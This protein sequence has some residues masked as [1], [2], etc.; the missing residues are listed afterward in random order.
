MRTDFLWSRA[1]TVGW[2]LDF[3]KKYDCW[4]WTT[5]QV[6]AH[7]VKPETVATRQRYADLPRIRTAAGVPPPADVMVS[8]E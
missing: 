2:L 7:I 3:T 6:Q 4:K 5:A 1:V 8:R